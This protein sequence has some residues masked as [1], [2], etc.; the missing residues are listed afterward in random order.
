MLLEQVGE[1]M[2]L[3]QV[4]EQMLL[5]VMSCSNSLCIALDV[6]IQES[7]K[8]ER[9]GCTSMPCAHTSMLLP[10]WISKKVRTRHDFQVV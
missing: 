9:T 10:W 7:F 5:D 2:L 6:V 1:Q 8:A 3:E 4:G